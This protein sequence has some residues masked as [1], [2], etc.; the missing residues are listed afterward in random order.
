VLDAAPADEV[1][2][3]LHDARPATEASLVLREDTFAEDH[4]RI[5]AGSQRRLARDIARDVG[6]SIERQEIVGVG[7]RHLAE[8]Q[9]LGLEHRLHAVIEAHSAAARAPAV[10]HEGRKIRSSRS[11][12]VIP[13]RFAVDFDDRAFTGG[14]SAITPP[15][16]TFRTF[17]TASVVVTALAAGN[18]RA[19]DTSVAIGEV[20][21][22]PISSGVDGAALK[23]AAERELR[24]VDSSRL[25]NHRKV[26]VSVAMLG[27]LEAPYGCTVNAVLRDAKTGTM[28]A[29]IEGSARAEG[30]TTTD[31]VRQQV[32]RVALRNAVRQIP[33][34]LA[35]N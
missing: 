21:A 24:Q 8:D 26:V 7:L 1:T 2:A 23:S 25:R 6:A 5:V 30:N 29:V 32:L 19:S 15:L 27:A 13:T 10:S 18:A 20:A 33:A 12:S 17:L 11:G 28:L 31:L 4:Q 9:P 14:A 16:M 3:R 22:P 34:A 35:A